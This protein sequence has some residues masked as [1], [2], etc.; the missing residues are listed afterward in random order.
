MSD[1]TIIEIRGEAAGIVARTG[2]GFAFYAAQAPYFRLEKRLFRS[3][4]EA[5]RAAHALIARRPQPF[6][7]L[8]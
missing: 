8:A 1:A 5:E 4:R 6:A 3:V 7:A 2:R